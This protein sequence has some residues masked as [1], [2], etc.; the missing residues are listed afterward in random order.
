V[1]MLGSDGAIT[2]GAANLWHWQSNPTDNDANDTGFSGGYVDPSG[3][4]ISPPDN[5]SFAEDDYTNTTGFFVVGGGF[6]GAPN[7]DPYASPYLILAGN[8]YAPATKTWT[9][10]MS[11][12]FTTD[13]PSYRVQLST[14]SSYY[15][16]FAVWQ[17]RL[18]ESAD[19][20]SVSQW[21]NL[22]VSDQGFSSNASSPQ[23]SGVSG[24][25][26]VSVAAGTLLAGFVIGSVLRWGTKEPKV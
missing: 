3:T 26:A 5:L 14:G 11:R 23:G 12:T 1:M 10:E 8:Q 21:Y 7:L 22:A 19:M 17:G 25:V 6:P 15:V 9:V 13:A 2:G 20:K 16:A 4:P 18:G 24:E